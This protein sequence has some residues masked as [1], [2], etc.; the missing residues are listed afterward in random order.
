MEPQAEGQP[1]MPVGA[2]T[3]EGGS[4]H[5]RSVS[6]HVIVVR[7][8]PAQR[9]SAWSSVVF[10]LVRR[11]L[12]AISALFIATAAL[13]VL[14]Q[15]GITI[16]EEPVPSVVF[17]EVIV[18]EVAARSTAGAVT[19]VTL[20]LQ[21]ADQPAFAWRTV[22]FEPGASIDARATVDMAA[23]ALPPFSPVAYWWELAT[24]S[25]ASATTTPATF[26]Y[27]DDRFAWQTVTSG[28]LTLHWYEGGA[29]FG[30]AALDTATAAYS[31]ANREIRAPLPERL[32]VYVYAN[33]RDVQAALQRVG[34]AW[35][36]GHADA[37][38][39]V[40]IVVVAPDLSAEFNLQ[41]EIPHE[42]THILMYRATGANYGRVPVWFNE[43]LAM[44]NQ[45]QSERDFPAVLAAARDSDG[46]L[47]FSSLCG[48]FPADPAQ[49]RL[50]YA[51]SESFTRY[52]RARFGAERIH[53]LVNGYGAGAGCAAGVEEVLD[54]PLATLEQQWLSD[55]VVADSTGARWAILA[56]WLI[57]G[58]L[59]LL[60]PILFFLL[61][62]RP[63]RRA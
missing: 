24:D 26:F 49:A 52:L 16:T 12:L 6:Q 39:G 40:V 32:D 30:Q 1:A 3:V 50:A 34:V 27:E 25:G 4:G 9:L 14:A 45:A 17:G 8:L 44:L 28:A 21:P 43:G 62:L 48:A 56:P 29:S 5:K 60:G 59:V 20:N 7:R 19:T 36:D 35:A 61:I 63:A 23:A 13:P 18:F 55:V 2:D 38:L 47:S 37:A 51:Q 42:L 11:G 15:T 58:G 57:V 54:V 31:A 10:G 53:A 41:R 46:F 33:T 22:T